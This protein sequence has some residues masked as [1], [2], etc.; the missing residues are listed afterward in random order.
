MLNINLKRASH[1]SIL[2]VGFM[3]LKSLLGLILKRSIA[4]YFVTLKGWKQ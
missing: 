4:G 2:L 3:V 1:A